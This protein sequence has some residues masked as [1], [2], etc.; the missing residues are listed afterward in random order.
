MFK[1][2]SGLCLWIRSLRGVWGRA[3]QLG[4]SFGKGEPLADGKVYGAPRADRRF[5]FRVNTAQPP[6]C[7]RTARAPGSTQRLPLL[8]NVG[9]EEGLI[10]GFKDGVR[11]V[12]TRWGG[13]PISRTLRKPGPLFCKMRLFG[14][15]G[16]SQAELLCE[17]QLP[18][19]GT[20]DRLR[21]RGIYQI[22]AQPFPGLPTSPWVLG[23]A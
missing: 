13:S 7:R 22:I 19:V 3:S 14:P 15:L 6:H 8:H 1:F 2:Y 16:P 23:G 4:V 5:S 21:V 12:S 10:V 9:S 18:A 20:H 17:A 11:A